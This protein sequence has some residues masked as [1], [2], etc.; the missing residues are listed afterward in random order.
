ME[1]ENEELLENIR[2]SIAGDREAFARIYDCT[3]R[4]VTGTVRFLLEDRASAED[5]IQEIYIE[6]YKSLPKFNP[7]RS[8]RSWVIGIAIRQVNNYRRR[9]WRLFRLLAKNQQ[10][11]SQET[12]PD[13][14]GEVADRLDSLEVIRLVDNLPYKYKQVIVLRYLYEYSQEE[15]ARILDIPVG[16]VKSRLHF[17]LEKLRNISYTNAYSLGKAGE[18]H[19]H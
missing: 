19:G 5:V 18:S 9:R 10:Y 12:E 15:I 8:F 3:V 16:T 11:T 2:R 6:I 1:Q 7:A 4:D 14:S 13:F 17:A